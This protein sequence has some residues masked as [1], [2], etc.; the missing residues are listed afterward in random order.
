MSHSEAHSLIS[1]L[2]EVETRQAGGA[3]PLIFESMCVCVCVCVG[4]GYSMVRPPPRHLSEHSCV[5]I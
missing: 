5:K 1:H 2:I 4:G 3:C